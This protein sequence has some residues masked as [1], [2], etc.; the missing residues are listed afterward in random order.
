MRAAKTTFSDLAGG[1]SFVLQID[2]RALRARR[3]WTHR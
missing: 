3:A 2:V 1:R